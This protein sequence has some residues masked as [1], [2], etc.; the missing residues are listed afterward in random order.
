MVVVGVAGLEFAEANLREWL[1]G[2]RGGRGGGNNETPDGFETP[3][4][5]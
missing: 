5:V 4:E 1:V 3:V 2:F